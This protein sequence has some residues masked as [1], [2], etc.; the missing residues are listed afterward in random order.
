MKQPL[1]Y[2]HTEANIAENVV[3]EPFVSIDKDV[4]IGEGTRIRIKCYHHARSSYR[5]KLPDFPWSSHWSLP[6]RI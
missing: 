3:I 1:A 4:I 6:L 2:V 5:Q